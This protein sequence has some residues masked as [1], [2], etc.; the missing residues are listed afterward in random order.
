MDTL[1]PAFP[2]T[3]QVSAGTVNENQ[4]TTGNLVSALMIILYCR[5]ISTTVD[6]PGSDYMWDWKGLPVRKP[7]TYGFVQ[8]A[9]PSS[10]QAQVPYIFHYPT[11]SGPL[12][13]GQLYKT[14]KK[15]TYWPHMANSPYGTGAGCPS[16]PLQG[17]ENRHQRELRLSPAAGPFEFVAMKI[18]VP[19]RK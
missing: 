12:H 2:Q 8:N 6:I 19:L 16:C 9:I 18:L 15:G 10:I 1:K 17:R 11:F 5:E 7:K 14:L 4:L 13:E 3:L